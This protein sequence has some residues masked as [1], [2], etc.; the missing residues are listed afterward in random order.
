MHPSMSLL[1]L[2][3]AW[4][5]QLITNMSIHGGIWDKMSVRSWTFASR[6]SGYP[7]IPDF[8]QHDVAVVFQIISPEDIT[9]YGVNNVIRTIRRRVGDG[10]CLL[11]SS[12]DI[13]VVEAAVAYDTAAADFLYEF[14][15]MMQFYE[16]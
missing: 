14:L 5:E 10:L 4:E 9:D 2:C 16:F 15:M 7:L 13:D 3:I 6:A 11:G 12:L 8:V 1:S